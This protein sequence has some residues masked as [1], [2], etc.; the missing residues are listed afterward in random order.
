M[1]FVRRNKFVNHPQPHM[2][3]TFDEFW[4]TL[5]R[6]DSLHA[7]VNWICYTSSIHHRIEFDCLLLFLRD[8]EY[9]NRVELNGI[10]FL[11]TDLLIRFVF[12]SSLF[13]LYDVSMSQEDP[14]SVHSNHWLIEKSC[15]S[16]T[17]EYLQ[18]LDEYGIRLK[19]VSIVYALRTMHNMMFCCWN[20]FV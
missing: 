10:K 15:A 18:S 6:I 3:R 7:N 1:K 13:A 20:L 19:W 12:L 4:Q 2:N 17:V 16:A 9:L 8:I 5:N 14:R 11:F